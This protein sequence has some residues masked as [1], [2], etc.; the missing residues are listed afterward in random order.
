MILKENETLEKNRKYSYDDIVNAVLEHAI[1]LFF[2]PT[3]E[4][5]KKYGEY[6]TIIDLS[7][8]EKSNLRLHLFQN[9]VHLDSIKVVVM[10]DLKEALEESL[11]EKSNVNYEYKKEVVIKLDDVS[12]IG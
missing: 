10:S 11:N 3:S 4:S 9:R 5:H 8:E 2:Y 7:E 1:N 12:N 6:L